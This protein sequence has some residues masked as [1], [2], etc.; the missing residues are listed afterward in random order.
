MIQIH[1]I[2]RNRDF[3]PAFTPFPLIIHQIQPHCYLR[4]TSNLCSM[5]VPVLYVRH[6]RLS[7][8]GQ[9]VQS[10]LARSHSRWRYQIFM[11]I[12][13]HHPCSYQIFVK[14]GAVSKAKAHLKLRSPCAA[15]TLSVLSFFLV[16]GAKRPLQAKRAPP[17]GPEFPPDPYGARGATTC[18]LTLFCFTIF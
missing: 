5:F 2:S 10:N 4:H 11:N 13:P 7:I 18:F 14:T 16:S 6:V 8:S 12:S 3:E 15:L 17:R 9:M 1:R